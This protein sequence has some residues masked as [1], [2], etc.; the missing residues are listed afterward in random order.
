[1]GHGRCSG[2]HRRSPVGRVLVD[3]LGWPGIFL[4]NVPVGLVAIVIGLRAI[5]ESADPQHAALDP[6]GQVLVIGALGA[7]SYGIIEARTHGWGSWITMGSLAAAVLAAALVPLVER[8]V[9]RPLLPMGLFGDARFTITN[10][11]SI[12]LGFA[13]NGAFFLLSALYL[14]QLRGHS[15]METGLL[16]LPSALAVL[17]ASLAAG[18]LNAAHGPRLPMLTGYVL[19]GAALG[20]MAVFDTETSYAV[21]AALFVVAGIGQGLA[22]TPAAAAVLEIVPRERSGIAAATVNT[23]RQVGTALGVAGS[24]DPPAVRP[25]TARGFEVEPGRGVLIRRGQVERPVADQSSGPR[26]VSVVFRPYPMVARS[27]WLHSADDHERNDPHRFP[28]PR[29]LRCA[30]RGKL[31]DRLRGQVGRGVDVVSVDR[32]MVGAFPAVRAR[33][34]SDRGA[35]PRCRERHRHGRRTLR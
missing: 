34:G 1:M 21:V 30:P 3:T 33:G 32:R 16:L 29:P 14:Q 24:G 15:A 4:V 23:S 18:R 22:I 19:T 5:P 7:L 25:E 2:R 12:A 28:D 20:A 9:A 26:C 10:L 11:A 17:P 27:G 8:R 35:V 13:A 31:P 6:A